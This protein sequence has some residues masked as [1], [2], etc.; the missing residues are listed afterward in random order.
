MTELK[1]CEHCNHKPARFRAG[2]GTRTSVQ[3]K[4]CSEACKRQAFYK[5]HKP[6]SGGN[7][8]TKYNRRKRSA[9]AFKD[10]ELEVL[11]PPHDVFK[12]IW[13]REGMNAQ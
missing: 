10:A 12:C 1:K 4:Y 7:Y 9:K 3:A 2:H 13:C 5:R 8:W 11:S 6:A